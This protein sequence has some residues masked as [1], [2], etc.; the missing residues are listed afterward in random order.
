MSDF[1]AIVVHDRGKML[2]FAADYKLNYK[3]TKWL[4]TY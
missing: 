3:L 1:C 2:N 4:I